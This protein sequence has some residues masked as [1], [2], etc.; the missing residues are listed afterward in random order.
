MQTHMLLLREHPEWIDTAVAWFSSKWGIPA[1]AYLES[2][3]DCLRCPT[4]IP[5]WYLVLDE[6]EQIIGGLGAIANDFH[7]RPDLTP[8]ICAVFVEPAYRGQG[9]ARAMLDYV[10]RDLAQLGIEDVWLLTDHTAFYEKC[11]W[12]FHCM[13]EEDGGGAA[14]GYHRDLR[15]LWEQG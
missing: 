8:N 5:Q 10:C 11:G 3:Q 15:P 1:E 14:R 4:G 13:I 7:K 2:I 9:V 6:T 12:H